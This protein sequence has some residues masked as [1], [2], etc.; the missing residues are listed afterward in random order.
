MYLH[1]TKF[2]VP[3]RDSNWIFQP[4]LIR[5]PFTKLLALIDF[6][7]FHNVVALLGSWNT[8]LRPRLP[9]KK[10]NFSYT[11]VSAQN[12]NLDFFSLSP[13]RRFLQGITTI[14]RGKYRYLGFRFRQ[15]SVPSVFFSSN[16]GCRQLLK[17]LFWFF[18]IWLH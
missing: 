8:V 4:Y 12:C 3:D 15:N 16:W 7:T 11:S 17:D 6:F 1:T 18:R 13:N 5:N 9:F 2:N 10:N 14:W